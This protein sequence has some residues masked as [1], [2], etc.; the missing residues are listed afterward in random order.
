VVK[1][2]YSL[3]Q[4][5]QDAIKIPRIFVK[6]DNGFYGKTIGFLNG[7]LA[8]R[9]EYKWSKSQMYDF[10]CPVKYS[11]FFSMIIVMKRAETLSREEFFNLNKFNFV[12]EHKLDSYGKLDGKVVVVDYGN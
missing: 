2:C 6:P 3:I 9:Y 4:V 7:W 11:F 5:V 10:L 1:L 12:Y 8:N